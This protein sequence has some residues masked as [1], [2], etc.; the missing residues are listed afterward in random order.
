MAHMIME[1][2]LGYVSGNSTW[3]GLPQYNCVGNRPVTM[4]EAALTVDFEVLKVPTWVTPDLP[5][6]SYS[7]IRKDKDGTTTV[8]APAVG[9]RY[10]ATPH[11]TLYN[12]F[13]ENLL[14]SFPLKIAGVGTL[15][16]G[17]TWF[18]QMV[19]EEYFIRGDESPN[20]LRLSYSH[21][22]GLDSHRIY[23]TTVRMVCDNTR[24]M[25]IADA[26]ANKMMQT[27]KHTLNAEFKINA[28]ME[29]FAQLHLAV[30][31]DK[32]L[33]E[34]LAGQEVNSGLVS[35]FMQEFFPKPIE[36]AS[37]RQKNQWE[38]DSRKVSDIFHSGQ[39]MT[40][41]TRTSKYALLNAYTDWADHHSY[42]RNDT[43]RWMDSQT[44][45]RSNM[46][47]MATDWLL[48]N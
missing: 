7:V 25:S 38:V 44:G 15:S 6:G 14:A 41:N 16:G 46:K 23:C 48:A 28:S 37:T 40:G 18:I 12:M 8:L 2:D 34:I 10:L 45:K 43:D 24:K 19:A 26:I 31:K 20:E 47:E 32:E 9:D 5:S 17:A 33:M 11:S 4:D 36:E 42:S 21:T 13:G 39:S 1:N 29:M 22:Y 35:A 3:H 30:Q 27:H